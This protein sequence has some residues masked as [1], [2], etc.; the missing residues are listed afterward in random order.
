MWLGA[1]CV[2]L[3]CSVIFLIRCHFPPLGFWR[4]VST[5]VGA[6]S[7]ATPIAIV[8][9][10]P[11]EAGSNALLEGWVPVLIVS[12][13]GFAVGVLFIL[14]G[15]WGVWGLGVKSDRTVDRWIRS[16][17]DTDLQGK[18]LGTADLGAADFAVG[19]QLTTN[20]GVSQKL[21]GSAWNDLGWGTSGWGA[22]GSAPLDVHRSAGTLVVLIFDAS[23]KELV[24][25]GDNAM[26]AARADTTTRRQAV[27][28]VVAQLL[29]KFPPSG[30]INVMR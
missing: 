15:L 4:G 22:G 20:D 16:A 25:R 8:F 3:V 30:Q 12:V 2:Y 29:T 7:V 5:F 26:A 11:F 23:T 1:F 21:T 28:E 27:G 24:W 13:G 6:I 17:I 19:Y 18:G 9:P 14:L 10:P